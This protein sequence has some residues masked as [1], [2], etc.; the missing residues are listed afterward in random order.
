M[1][2]TNTDVTSILDSSIL[3]E[4][5]TILNRWLSNKNKLEDASAEG[6]LMEIGEAL[7]ALSEDWT[8]ILQLADKVGVKGMYPLFDH[9]YETIDKHMVDL[10]SSYQDKN[11]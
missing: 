2:T 8:K 10:T 7:I 5:S 6:N 11:H 3:V 4:A 9:A 1:T